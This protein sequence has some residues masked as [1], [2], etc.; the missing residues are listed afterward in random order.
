MTTF[1]TSIFRL[2]QSKP[3]DERKSIENRIKYFEELLNYGIKISIIC[4]PFYEKILQPYIQKYSNI[5]IIEIMELKNTVISKI[6]DKYEKK[7]GTLILPTTRNGDK[8]NKE[9][10]ILMNSKL[11]FIKKAIDKNV[12]NTKYFC[13]IDFSIKYI[14]KNE[15]K[16]KQNILKI[17][18]YQMPLYQNSLMNIIIPGCVSKKDMF[19]LDCIDWRFCGGIIYGYKDDLIDFYDLNYIYFKQFIEKY[20]TLVWEVNIWSWMEFIEIFNPHW[21]YGDHNDSIFELVN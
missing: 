11:E 15:E 1:V 6:C 9:Y 14:V 19:H 12:W 7:Y 3:I 13:W 10:M 20:K 18:Q 16:T 2:N 5:K 21:T 8:D 4:C 17:S